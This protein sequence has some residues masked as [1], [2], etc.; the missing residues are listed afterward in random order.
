MRTRR[1]LAAMLGLL[2]ASGCGVTAQRA[3]P[4]QAEAPPAPVEQM[5][6]DVCP[7][8][9]VIQANWEPQ[10]EHGGVYQLVGPGY[11]VDAN[12][13][14]VSGPLVVGGRNTGVRVEVRAG[15]AAIG[16][17][18]VPAQM[19]LDSSI[20][21]GMV[22]TDLAVATSARQPVTAVAAQ[23]IKSPQMLMWDPSSH[24]DW[25][26]IADI[27]A[28]DARVVV[29]KDR[30]Y[31]AWLVARGLL[32][33]AQ[34][35]RSYN[36]NPARFVADPSIVLQGIASGEP[37]VYEHKVSSWRKPVRY[38]LLADVGYQSYLQALSVRTDQ[39]PALSACLAKLVPIIQQAQVDYLANPAPTNDLILKLVAAYN[40]GWD[41]TPGDAAYAVTTMK[42]LEIV[43]N[44]SAGTLGGL[45]PARVQAVIDANVPLLARDGTP[46]RP[47]LTA[48]DIATNRFISP[49]IGLR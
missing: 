1:A 13:K 49:A 48:V 45:D 23:L 31:P 27:G 3:A 14:T 21:L 6:R 15:G 30:Q 40:D 38:Q 41:Y 22:E 33:A 11:T 5:L 12:H 46:A 18:A 42:R 29:S 16:F 28:S 43:A 32:K 7:P 37:Y 36:G 25:R 2:A 35:D 8:T 9:V 19:Y 39:L 17:V 26:G 10:A 24:P 20:T 34:I 44:D 47:G 4:T